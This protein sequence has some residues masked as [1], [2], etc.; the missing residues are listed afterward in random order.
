MGAS[1]V[2]LTGATGTVGLAVS[3]ALLARGHDV[4]GYALEP[5]PPIAAAAMGE[6]P[7]RYVF[8]RG[9]VLDSEALMAVILDHRPQT[10]IHGAALTPTAADERSRPEATMRINVEAPV[11]V[12]MVTQAARAH[13]PVRRLIHLGSVAAYG[14]E[15]A[16]DDILVEE[17]HQERP[18]SLYEIS[19][20]AGEQAALRVARLHGLEMASLRLGDV[21]G[22]WEHPTAHRGQM[23]APFQVLTM[24]IAGQEIVLPREGRKAW[25]YTRDV[26]EAVAAA[27]EVARLPDAIVNVSTP[28]VWSVA[29][30]C[31]AL[32]RHLDVDFRIDPAAANVVLFADNAP[33]SLTRLGELG[34]AGRY[35]LDRAAAD[36]VE[37]MRTFPAFFG[38]PLA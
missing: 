9:D 27:V 33:M 38:G 8:V 3:E 14:A 24:A 34:F 10:V 29:D 6:L 37:W 36:Y 1:T 11:R 26:G 4:I 23:S 20:L 30:W 15:T 31:R 16:G 21:F 7:G 25:I 19:K 12:A 35:P 18:E 2:L 13:A 17:T 22:P 32:S 28:H 5:P